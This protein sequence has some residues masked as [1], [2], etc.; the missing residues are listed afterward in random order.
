MAYMGQNVSGIIIKKKK[1]R[2]GNLYI[3]MFIF[4]FITDSAG[5]TSHPMQTILV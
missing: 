1:L 2:D 3:F 5:M 4:I